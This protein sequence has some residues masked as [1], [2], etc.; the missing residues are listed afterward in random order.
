MK[1]LRYLFV[2]EKA[3]KNYSGYFP[4]VSG[5]VTTARTIE[6]MIVSGSEALE[7]HFEDESRLPRPKS[8]A[9]HL[10]KGGLKLQPTDVVTWIEH[11]RQPQLTSA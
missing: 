10:E 2:I 5:C 9:W 11:H 3:A 6:K 8:L 4:D 7:L 1:N